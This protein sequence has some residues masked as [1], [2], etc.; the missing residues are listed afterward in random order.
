M[1]SPTGLTTRGARTRERIVCTAATLMHEQGL[2]ATTNEQ[3]RTAAGVSG[4]QLSHYFADKAALVAAVV[5][6][7]DRRVLDHEGTAWA[8]LRDV[9]GLRTWRNAIVASQTNRQ[10]CRGGC[11][12]GSLAA[13]LA[14]TDE[15]SREHVAAVLQRWQTAIET[16][17]ERLRT[18]GDLPASTDTHRLGAAVLASLQGGLLL[19]QVQRDVA[20]LAAALDTVIDHIETLNATSS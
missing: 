1:I 8:G 17:L 11:P 10:P 7:Q 18:V 5:D 13:A 16:G 19:A 12:V 6:L 14:E 9:A 4:S 3:V 2:A 15:G 20:P